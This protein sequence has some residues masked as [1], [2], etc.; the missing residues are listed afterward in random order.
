MR[1]NMEQN[2]KSNS[3]HAFNLL[4]SAAAEYNNAEYKFYDVGFVKFVR[5]GKAVFM[6]DDLYV[7]PEFRGTPRASIMLGE[8]TKFMYD[9]G[10]V[11]YYGRVW[12]GSEHHDKRVDKFKS[13]GMD[14]RSFNDLYTI[15]HSI[16]KDR[17]GRF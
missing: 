3:L 5:E 13:W 2:L 6:I 4:R 8:F 10:I 15:V 12:K 7:I 16:V 1:K 17:Y 14:V 11:S 9:S